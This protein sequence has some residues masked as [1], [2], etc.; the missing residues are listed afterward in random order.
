MGIR[1]N[2]G[3]T[4]AGA[5][6]VT[7]DADDSTAVVSDETPAPGTSITLTVTALDGATPAPFRG[8]AATVS[9]ATGITVGSVEG[10]RTDADGVVE[11]P[12][13]IALGAA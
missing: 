11:V 12:I 1:P 6:Y 8:V 10:L 5:T 3:V 13:A 2:Y 4:F 7:P 9:S